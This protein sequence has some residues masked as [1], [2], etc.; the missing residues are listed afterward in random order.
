M[1]YEEKLWFLRYYLFSL[2]QELSNASKS[3]AYDIY[4][5]YYEI[6]LVFGICYPSLTYKRIQLG[7]I[8]PIILFPYVMTSE[9]TLYI[10]FTVLIKK[11]GKIA[12]KPPH[13][14]LFFYNKISIK[15]LLLSFCLRFFIIWLNEI[16]KVISMGLT[17]I[18]LK[19]YI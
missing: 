14:I 18:F 19:F 11:T 3:I 13:R 8:I 17:K 12:N 7:A 1:W 9:Y 6:I 4:R 15:T 10:F 5:S 2:N 16:A